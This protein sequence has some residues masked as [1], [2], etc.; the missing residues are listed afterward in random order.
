MSL[1]TACRVAVSAALNLPR[2]DAP[3]RMATHAGSPLH[4]PSWRHGRI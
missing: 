4:R 2:G 1:V 3:S